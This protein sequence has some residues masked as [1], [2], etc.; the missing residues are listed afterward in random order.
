MSNT[1]T[2]TQR[3]KQPEVLVLD[4]ET[5]MIQTYPN[6]NGDLVKE[7][8]VN[9]KDKRCHRVKVTVYARIA[10]V[11]SYHAVDADMKEEFQGEIYGDSLISEIE[12]IRDLLDTIY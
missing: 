2:Q 7:Y 1:L 5:Q 12:A 11:V 10:G 4:V 3:E 6:S 9:V 8:L